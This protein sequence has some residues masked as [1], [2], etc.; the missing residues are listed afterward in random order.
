[1]LGSRGAEVAKRIDTYATAVSYS[2]PVADIADLDLLHPA[3]G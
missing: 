3:L 2:A 1:V